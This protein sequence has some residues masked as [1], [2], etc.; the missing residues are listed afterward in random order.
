M[1]PALWKTALIGMSLIPI[2]L[3]P[4]SPMTT[5]GRTPTEIALGMR[6]NWG[7]K[8]IT[9]ALGCTHVA[10]KYRFTGKPYLLEGAEELSRMGCKVIKLWFNGSPSNSYPFNT[11]LPASAASLMEVARHPE[12]AAVFAMPFQTY[13]LETYAPQ[14]VEWKDG[15]SEEEARV[16]TQAMEE[17]TRYLAQTYRKTG[18]T[19]I[20]QNWEGDNAIALKKRP[21]ETWDAALDGMA[22]WMNARQLGVHRGRQG[23]E[24]VTFANALE[25]NWVPG[26]KEKTF[27]VPILAD[28][29]APKTACDLYSI[30]SWGT[31]VAGTEEDLALKLE[32]IAERVPASAMY[33]RK[34]VMVGEFGAPESIYEGGKNGHSEFGKDSGL[35]Q[36]EV[37]RRQIESALKWG[38]PYIVYWELYCNEWKNEKGGRDLARGLQVENARN[39]EVRGFWLVRADGTKPPVYELFKGLWGSP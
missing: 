9:D 28:R 20:F 16:E 3:A 25:M 30:S 39:D 8:R 26:G 1:T 29:V 11:T 38:A 22:A 24:G 14:K 12:Y 35:Q 4:E 23:A 32:Y 6:K 13:I 37:T 5:D 17:V 27:E 21:P 10:G 7:E 36:M 31:K 33:G 34:N 18:K 2:P 19:F 15:L